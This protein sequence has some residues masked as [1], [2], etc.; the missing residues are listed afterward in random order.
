M[1]DKEKQEYQTIHNPFTGENMTAKT[2]TGKEL[3][4]RE[5]GNDTADTDEANEQVEDYMKNW[6]DDRL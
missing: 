3:L 1:E 6:E 2:Y 5:Q 4:W